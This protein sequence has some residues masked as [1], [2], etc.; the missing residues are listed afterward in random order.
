MSASNG[1]TLI[2]TGAESVAMG[3]ADVAVARDT[4]ALS[5]N[6]A[7]LSQLPGWAHDGFVGAA[8]AT[9]VAHAD[10]FG[11]DQNVANWVVPVGGA[12]VSKRIDGHDVTLGI[13]MFAQAGAGSIYNDLT[14]PF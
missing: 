10:Q 9:D 6:P 4:T 7:G 11:N 13:G 12:G 14:T 1:L 8:F 2:G 5:T 3:G